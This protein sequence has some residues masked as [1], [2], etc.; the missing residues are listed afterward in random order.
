MGK[1]ARKEIDD[2]GNSKFP[3]HEELG[4]ELTKAVLKRLRFD[5]YTTNKV[6]RLVKWYN[7]AI[8]TTKTG[9]RRAIFQVGEDLFEELLKVK[10]AHFLAGVS[11]LE[12]ESEELKK[13]SKIFMIYKEILESKDC[14]SLRTLEISGKDMIAEGL[15]PGVEVG[16]L[17]DRLLE[18]VIENPEYNNKTHLILEVRKYLKDKQ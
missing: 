8:P 10:R 17:L 12:G 6:T 18:Q 9:I 15:K 16:D 11:S 2:E 5:N 4:T 13:L 3:G 14:V 1:P 7:I